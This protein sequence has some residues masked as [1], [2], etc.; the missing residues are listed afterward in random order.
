MALDLN[1]NYLGWSI[2]DWKDDTEYSIIKTGVYN[3]KSLNDKEYE[4]KKLK[5]PSTDNRRIYINNKRKHEVIEVSKNLVDVARHYGCEIFSVED[6]SIQSSDKKKGKGFN[7][8]CNN[9]WIRSG[10]IN[11]L[12]KRCNIIGIKFHKSPAQYSSTIGNILYRENE[13]PDMVNSSI[14]IGRRAF[15]FHRQ[16]V[17]KTISKNKNVVFPDIKKFDE[18]ISQSL[19]E[20]GINENFNDWKSLH[21]Y[22]KNSKLMYRVPFDGNIKWFKFNSKNSNVGF[23]EK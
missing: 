8:L 22:I 18:V 17:K 16:Y 21:S 4:F 6:L 10:F 5:L 15:E 14:E 19:E 12:N 2:V 3:F 7:R 23:Y 9:Q 11:N 1:P 20:F 13:T